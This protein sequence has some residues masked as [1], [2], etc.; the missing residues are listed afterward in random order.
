MIHKLQ[1][2]LFQ[3][4]LY[5]LARITPG[6]LTWASRHWRGIPAHRR[7][8]ELYR[9]G[10]LIRP[11]YYLGL[12]RAFRYAKKLGLEQF[13][14]LEFGVAEGNGI[15]LLQT[16]AAAMRE[17][18]TF[19]SR[20]AKIIGYDTFE[21]LP[22]IE[23][24]RDGRSTWQTG[25]YPG[26]LARLR[27]LVDPALVQLE[28]G[29]FSESIPRTRETLAAY[30]PLFV[31]VDCDL[32]ASTVSI[33]AALFPAHMPA[34]SFWYFDDTNLNFY[35]EQVGEQ[36]AIREFNAQPGNAFEFVPDYAALS[37]PVPPHI[38]LK[39]CFHCIDND[40]FEDQTRLGAGVQTLPLDPAR[41]LNV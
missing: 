4:V 40:R 18:P 31:I 41:Y 34:L 2:G 27:A 20:R 32:Y 9:H 33:F 37:E 28:P 7:H 15:L 21:G 17:H 11:V 29:L 16:L 6:P 19:R 12:D 5:P 22:Q 8:K 23:S 30:P 35:S 39:H 3:R 36:A 10:K 13:S 38:A 1:R 24:V 14:I 26:D 25:D